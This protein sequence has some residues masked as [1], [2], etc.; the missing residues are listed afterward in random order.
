MAPLKHTTAELELRYARSCH[1]VELIAKDEALRKLRVEN[2]VL[3]DDAIEARDLWAEEQQRA[4]DFEASVTRGL[5][6]AEEA[7]NALL[8]LEEILNLRDRE[9]ST[10]QVG[11]RTSSTL[12]TRPRTMR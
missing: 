1:Q 4:D 5:E 2:H 11:A 7:E 6:R 3:D 12:T 10:L 8:E 9:L